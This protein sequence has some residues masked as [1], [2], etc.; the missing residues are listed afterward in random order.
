[1][2]A[3][4]NM[5]IDTF[6][7]GVAL[8]YKNTDYIADQ[9]LPIV[10]A[11]KESGKI[12]GYGVEHY[13]LDFVARAIGADAARGD[14]Q[15]VTPLTFAADDWEFE[16]PVDDRQRAL[17]DDP[18]DAERDATLT[19]V[20]KILAKRE[21]VVGTLMTTSG[22]FGGTTAAGTV[23]AT[24]AT[25]TPITNIRTAMEAIRGRTGV[26]YQNMA[27]CLGAGLY[28]KLIQC[29]QVKNLF[30][31]T[32]P[33]AAGPASIKPSNV[34]EIIG[35]GSVFVG[36]GVKLTSKEG[37]ANAF[38]DLWGT[39]TCAIYVKSGR[40]SLMSP[41]FGVIISPTV[42][43]FK[44]AV[45]AVEKYREE[46]KHSDIVRAQALFDVVAVTTALGQIITGA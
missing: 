4:T 20:E 44:G 24:S 9:V 18:F 40:P 23:W 7:T 31:N 37:A 2:P 42:P 39:S 1:M 32:I 15:S 28:N 22:N 33:G 11:G 45:I 43:G 25:A 38:A 41:G 36:P 17:Y 3:L 21:D 6:L 19:C 12:A 46:R 10:P 30:I 13:R 16:I 26:G 34:A 5:H 14:Y 35:I 29:D 27:A 8:G